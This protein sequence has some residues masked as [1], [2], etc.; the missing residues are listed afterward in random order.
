MKFNFKRLIFQVY[1]LFIFIVEPAVAQQN[2]AY[3]YEKIFEMTRDLLTRPKVQ[4]FLKETFKEELIIDEATRKKYGLEDTKLKSMTETQ[5]FVLLQDNPDIWE[6]VEKYLK[7]VPSEITGDES[8]KEKALHAKWAEK[9]RKAFEKNNIKERFSEM[10]NPLQPLTLEMEDGSA[11]YKNLKKYVNH[12]HYDE[13]GE[14]K[15]A[16]NMLKGWL[17]FINSTEKELSLNVF[18]FD[19]EEIADALVAKAQEGKSI[20]VGIDKGVIE[21]RPEVKLIFD[22]LKAGGVKVVAVD[23]VGLN[24]QKMATQDWSISGKGKVLFSSGNLTHSCTNPAGDLHHIPT[25]KRPK[26]SVPNANHMLV[27]DSSILATVVHNQMVKTLD[28]EYQLRGKEF[29]LSGAFKVFGEKKAS[30]EIPE[31]TITFTPGGGIRSV[32]KNVISRVLD[33]ASGAVKM[34]QFAFSSGTV[35]DALFEWAKRE[36]E[37]GRKVNLQIVGDTPFS[38]QYWSV[39]LRMSGLEYDPEHPEKGYTPIA[40]NRWEKL[41]GKKDYEEFKK[42]IRIA[43]PIYGNHKLRHEGELWEISSKIHHKILTIGDY[44]IIGTSFNFSTGAETNNE[45]ILVIKDSEMAKWTQGMVRYHVEHSRKTV[46]EEAARKNLY[47]LKDEVE[48]AEVD[49]KKTKPK[50][51]AETKVAAGKALSMKECSDLY[52]G[53][54]RKKSIVVEPELDAGAVH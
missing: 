10:N 23:S 6:E 28:P 21:A 20:N 44:S 13:N 50:T 2:P 39:L 19:I 9:F 35:E 51:K 7:K 54:A 16:D 17:D 12:A 33:F 26:L 37:A 36:V 30:G 53:L 43:S 31:L 52:S 49:K 22:K 47:K 32:N 15:Q 27:M 14:L 25:A 38:T 8:E 5:L 24:H 3:N 4:E 46:S 29:P 40:D 1:F 18:D 11:G 48:D 45:Q 42:G 34:L 41:M